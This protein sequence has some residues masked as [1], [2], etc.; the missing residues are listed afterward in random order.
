MVAVERWPAERIREQIELVLSAWGM[1]EDKRV[2]T[3]G[4]MVET[5]LM[6]IDSH[7]I[8]MLI[9][10]E[11][12]H[13]AGQLRLDA[14]PRIVRQTPATALIDG[15]ANLGHPVAF[16]AMQL[17]IEKALAHDLGAVSVFNSH[18]FGACGCYALMAAR[19]NL[20]GLVASTSRI[21]T[22]VPT[23]GAERVLGTNP[24]CIAAPARRN[25]PVLLDMST[26]VVAANKVKTYALN[27]KPI[28]AGWVTGPD[29]GPLTD[30]ALAY[31]LLFAGTGGGLNP[32]GGY[33]TQMGGHKGY[34]LGLVVQILAGTLSGGSFSPIR[35]R[36]QKPSDPDNIGHFFLAINPA[37]FRPIE[38]FLDDLD[39]A[40]DLLR[41]TR[42][43]RPDEPVL[44][45][46]DPEW[47]AREERLREGIPIP[48]TLRDR[49]R[50]IAAAA[51][52]PFVL[53]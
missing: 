43:V 28:P 33:G 10:Y 5:D 41:S 25:P 39:A 42:P 40:A 34:G 37:A 20:I 8:S 27:G 13:K 2:V 31:D 36:T 16:L 3:A 23:R 50:D 47:A 22:V 45:P 21:V 30:S 7:G 14:D 6:G 38:A 12:M 4:L 19:R 18:H 46:G 1:P 29:G 15:G 9:L 35:N 52:A 32:I 17:A 44:V 11:Q 26:S 49:L 51:G 24:L 48:A 53:A